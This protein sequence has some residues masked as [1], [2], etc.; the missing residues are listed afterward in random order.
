MTMEKAPLRRRKRLAREEPERIEK[1]TSKGNEVVKGKMFITTADEQTK[2]ELQRSG[3]TYFCKSGGRYYF[4]YDEPCMKRMH[5]FN[6]LNDVELTN[7]L[8]FC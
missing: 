1:M 2:Y 8:T 7:I 5:N 6:R 3:F 4:S